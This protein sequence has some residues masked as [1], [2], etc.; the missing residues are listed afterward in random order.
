MTDTNKLFVIKLLH[1]SIWLFFNVVI[2]YFVIAVIRDRIDIWAWIC[3]GLISLEV[4]TLAVFKTVCPVT[5]IARKYS[6]SNADNFD[7]F[8]PLW[9]AR[10]NKQIYSV[11]V[12]IGLIMLVYRLLS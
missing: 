1:T 7:I 2:F 5:L 6:D 8:L 10:Y 9:L 3:L 4:L 12:G 11:I